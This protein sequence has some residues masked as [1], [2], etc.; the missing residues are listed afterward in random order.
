MIGPETFEVGPDD[1]DAE[2][3]DNGVGLGRS[4][5]SFAERKAIHLC[6]GL[7]GF[8]RLCCGSWAW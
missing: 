3:R 6:F 2:A 7:C 5:L 8:C 4:A 1:Q